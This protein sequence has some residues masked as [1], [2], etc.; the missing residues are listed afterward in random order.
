MKR[1]VIALIAILAALLPTLAT[2]EALTNESIITLHKLGLG[3]DVL[4]AKIETEPSDFKT[5]TES[6]GKLL[7]AGIPQEVI[8]KMI[9]PSEGS[10]AAPS[11]ISSSGSLHVVTQKQAGVASR[12]ATNFAGTPC[13]GLRPGI[14]SEDP[15]EPIRI[16][17][18]K[19]S[20]EGG[21][22]GAITAITRNIVS[23]KSYAFLNGLRASQQISGRTPTFLFCFEEA[24]AGLAH[25]TE[26]SSTP[27]D[28]VF[29]QLELRPKKNLRRLQVGKSNFWAGNRSGAKLTSLVDFSVDELADG[30]YRVTPQGSITTGEYAFYVSSSTSRGSLSFFGASVAETAG[31]FY[32]FGYNG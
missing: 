12:E 22:S 27:E 3:V 23:Q 29:A 21:S 2:A 28:F 9:N 31:R 24:A 14:Y 13:Q 1:T 26:G 17:G 7:Q 6:L 5:D 30:V 15:G 19:A 25:E 4:I 20:S 8:A 11:A 10:T 16:R 32:D 18:R